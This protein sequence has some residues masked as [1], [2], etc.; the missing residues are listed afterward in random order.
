MAI[1]KKIVS[2]LSLLGLSLVSIGQTYTIANNQIGMIFLN[3]WSFGGAGISFYDFDHDGWDDLSIP[4]NAQSPRFYRNNGN[5]TMTYS[6][7]FFQIGQVKHI[8]WVDYDN[9]GDEDI[10]MTRFQSSPLLL[11]NDGNFNFTNVTTEAGFLNT[12]VRIYGHS[13]GDYDRDG[14][15]DVYVCN[16][17]SFFGLSRNYFYENDGDGTF[18]EKA[19]TLGIDNG[20][21]PSFQSVWFDYDNDGWPDLYV[22]NDL[23]VNPNALYK[24][25]GNGT[26]TDVSV[27]SGTA[28]MIDAMSASIGDYD[29]DGWFDIYLSNVPAQGNR[30]LRNNG[31]GTFNEV[32]NAAGAS[33]GSFCWGTNW[34][35]FNND[36][37]LDIFAAASLFPGNSPSMNYIYTNNGDNTFSYNN[38]SGFQTSPGESY[39]SAV[40]DYNNDGYPD[41]AIN[42][43]Q[44]THA[45]LW[46]SSGGTN[47]WVKITLHGTISNRNAIGSRIELSAGGQTY[48]RY[49]MAGDNYLGQDSQHMLFGLGIT[50]VVD[51][52]KVIWPSGLEEVFYDLPSQLNHDLVEGTTLNLVVDQPTFLCPGDS[53]IL[54][55]PGLS[56]IEWSDGSTGATLVVTENGTYSGEVFFANIPEPITFGPVTITIDPIPVWSFES[57]DLTCYQSNDGT[58]SVSFENNAGQSI[59]WDNGATTFLLDNLEPGTYNATG[60]TTGNCPVEVSASIS[61]PDSLFVE[62][63]TSDVTCFGGSDGTF[64]ITSIGGG[65]GIVAPE[66]EFNADT[67]TAGSYDFT[68]LDENGCVS[69]YEFIITEP[70]EILIDLSF[71]DTP[72]GS[73]EGEVTSNVEGGTPPYQYLWTNGAM[74]ENIEGLGAGTIGLW[75]IDANECSAYAEVTISVI[76]GVD[77]MVGSAAVRYFP[78]PMSNELMITSSQTAVVDLLTLEGKLCLSATVKGT[79]TMQTSELPAG[80]YLLRIASSD[81]SKTFRVVKTKN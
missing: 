77:E 65:T 38:M 32:A 22:I 27:Q 5:G 4:S 60:T 43:R 41:I 62:Y 78:N 29:R 17:D 63:I 68:I 46:G 8:T 55:V 33:I 14:D 47:K 58:I 57:T 40:G 15:L 13:W 16:W 74:T 39:G 70:T 44:P 59:L 61:G 2:V 25:N 64:A 54:S 75:V 50:T 35:D 45:Q 37:H 34:L 36:T 10:F 49:T 51:S 66:F 24:N 1:I 19:L 52:V 67:L 48:Y 73:E 23:A 28:L 72:E 12:T 69:E 53:A 6:E 18:T 21:E 56:T 26:F 71:T 7:Y 80:V 30:L 11:Q 31:N 3:N 76:I 20:A 42:N 9:D 79:A 81:A